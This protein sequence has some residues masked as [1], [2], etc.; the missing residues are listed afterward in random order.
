MVI[1]Q[2]VSNILNGHKY[3]VEMAMFNVQRAITPKVGKPK[4][5]FICS[6]T[7]LIVFSICEKFC[8]NIEQ[9]QVHG[10]KIFN[11]YYVQRAT[12]PKVG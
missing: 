4:L 9:T 2:M 7:C 1:S 6:A 8:K 10:C 12:T 3:M 11:T 5:S